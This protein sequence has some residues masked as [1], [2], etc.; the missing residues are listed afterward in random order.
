MSVPVFR[1]NIVNRTFDDDSQ[2]S[3]EIQIEVMISTNAFSLKLIF[4]NTLY[5]FLRVLGVFLCSLSVLL[6]RISI[7]EIGFLSQH[8]RN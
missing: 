6:F 4:D 3:F 5:I 1:V 2:S 8:I 7:W